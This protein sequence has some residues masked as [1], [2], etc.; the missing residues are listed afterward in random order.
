MGALLPSRSWR[1]IVAPYARADQRRAVAQLLKTGLPFLIVMLSLLCGARRHPGLTLPLAVPAA[2]LLVRLFAIQ[3][4]CGHGS[5]FA[6]RRANDL[7]GRVLG[8]LTLT[9]YAFWRK[10]HAIHHANSVIP[11]G[12][13]PPVSGRSPCANVNRYRCGTVFAIGVIGIQSCCSGWVRS[14]Y[15][16]SR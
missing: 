10:N 15:S 13:A 8:V 2:L 1:E 4:D 9:P 14:F 5:F 16:S 7:V 6:S 12:A 11:T 3:H